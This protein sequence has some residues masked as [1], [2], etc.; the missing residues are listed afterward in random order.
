MPSSPQPGHSISRG[1]ELL[2]A[3]TDAYQRE[4]ETDDALF[5]AQPRI[6][7]HLDDTARSTVRRVVGQLVLEHRPAVLDLMAGIDS[8]LPTELRTSRLVG[9]G[10]NR[11][12]LEHNARLDERVVHDLNR[13]AHLPFEDGSFDVVLNTVSIQYVVR[14]VE[15]F[16][17]I[18]RVLRPGGLFLVV[19]SN[20]TFATK[21]VR[22][23]NLCTE[24]EHLWLVA[25]YF[26]ESGVFED[27]RV[28]LSMG[29][30]RP[31]Y[32]RHADSGMPS[33][34]VFAVW[35]DRVGTPAGRP[36]RPDPT[37][38]EDER[39]DPETLEWRT[40]AIRHT[41]RC[42]YCDEKLSLWAV[43]E[44][45]MSG[46]GHDLLVCL[47][48]ACPYV[49]RGWSVMFRQGV[50][51]ASYRLCYDPRTERTMP[52]SVPNLSAIKSST[53]G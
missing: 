26:A 34:P 4:D 11:T 12:E 38:D 8:H 15:L 23:W 39:L 36:P 16:L 7:H 52:I 28:F 42:P 29:R 51:G 53:Q 2:R 47:N 45:P 33:D 44:N 24:H 9:L 10:L 35:A 46:W 41:M 6:V 14:P 31:E 37:T 18:A 19:F 30:P 21:A 25:D 20:R 17:E 32:D 50:V 13:E 49:V 1:Y 48:D 43:S 27:P 22:L 5:Y 40:E 3:R